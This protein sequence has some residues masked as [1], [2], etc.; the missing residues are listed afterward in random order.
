M[1]FG[2]FF[3]AMKM[4]KFAY[5]LVSRLQSRRYKSLRA[6]HLHFFND[7]TIVPDETTGVFK[8]T[9]HLDTADMSLE[10]PENDQHENISNRFSFFLR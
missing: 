3:F 8:A 9:S 2:G 1:S 6:K 4:K 10:Q 5:H 7:K